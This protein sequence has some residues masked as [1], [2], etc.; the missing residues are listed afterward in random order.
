MNKKFEELGL[1]KIDVLGLSKR[2][3]KKLLI[4]EQKF[5]ELDSQKNNG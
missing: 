3:V 1:Q 5:G 4:Y 2:Q